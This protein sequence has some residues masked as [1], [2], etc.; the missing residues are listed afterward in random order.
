MMVS[1]KSG[2]KDDQSCCRE[3]NDNVTSL[4]SKAKQLQAEHRK[5]MSINYNTE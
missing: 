1:L 2:N 3:L 4:K 5:V